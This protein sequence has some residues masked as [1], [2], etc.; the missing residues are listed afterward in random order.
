VLSLCGGDLLGKRLSTADSAARA[1]H[2]GALRQIQ[3][4]Q[5]AQHCGMLS[6]R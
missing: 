3:G 5:A 6:F 2:A 4:Q 1:S